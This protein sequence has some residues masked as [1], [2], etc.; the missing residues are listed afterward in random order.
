MTLFTGEKRRYGFAESH[1]SSVRAVIFLLHPLPGLPNVVRTMG[2]QYVFG[3]S[4]AVAAALFFQACGQKQPVPQS[5]AA[6]RREFQVKGVVREL[7]P[8]E[9]EVVIK[10]EE[11]PD[12][13][14]AMTMTFE[15][16]EAEA[17]Q[18]LSTND[19]VSFTMIVTERDGWIENIRKI[20]VETNAAPAARPSTRI[21][22]DVDPLVVGDVVPNYVFTNSLGKTMNLHDLKGQAY[23]FT[24]IFTRC[25][26]PTFCPRMNIN[27][28]DTY[29]ILEAQTSGPTNWHLLSISFDPDF[30][31]PERLREYSSHYTPDPAKWSWVTGAMIEIDAIAEQ[32]GLTFAFENGTFNHNLRTVVVDKDGRLRRNFWGNEWTAEQLAEEIIAGAEGR[33]IPKPEE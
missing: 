18:G 16:K 24:F 12:Y 33:P 10:H 28:A 15:V 1:F 21:V 23:A 14:A 27:F 5:D 22:R 11:I 3:L 30:D 8:E 32:V 29:K 25:P 26:F 17:L 9:K 2:V 31:T 13:M 7:R 6:G 20:G 4:L 19:Q